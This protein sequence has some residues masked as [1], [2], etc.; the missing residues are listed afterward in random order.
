MPILLLILLIGVLGY[1]WITRR[2]STLTRLCRWRLDRSLGAAGYRC[3]ACGATCTTETGKEPRHC[4]RP[5][6]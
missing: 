5:V 3:V 6:D 2:G 4:L 1:M